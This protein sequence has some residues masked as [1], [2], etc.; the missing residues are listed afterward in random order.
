MR[1]IKYIFTCICSINITR[2]E[3]DLFHEIKIYKIH[4]RRKRFT[5]SLLDSR[6][7]CKMVIYEWYKWRY[8]SIDDLIAQSKFK[9]TC[10]KKQNT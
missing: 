2:H 8:E 9:R 10:I 7:R 5:T 1:E 6:N 4:C 3:E